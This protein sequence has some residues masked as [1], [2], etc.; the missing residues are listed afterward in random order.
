MTYRR[1]DESPA[2]YEARLERANEVSNEWFS[3]LATAQT[4]RFNDRMDVARA[5]KGAPRWDRERAAANREFKET[6]TEAS[7]IAEMVFADMMQFGEVLE[8]TSYAFDEVKR[9]Q[10]MAQAAE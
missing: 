5:Y 3:S 4:A 2:E 1:H 6:T 10:T 9:D 7:R 8:A